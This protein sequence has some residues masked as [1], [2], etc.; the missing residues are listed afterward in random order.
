MAGVPGLEPRL[1]ESKSD[2]LPLHYTPTVLLV[3]SP[4]IEL[5]IHPYHGCVMPLNYKSVFGP[6]ART[7]TWI[8]QLSVATEYKPAVLPLNYRRI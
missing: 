4:R 3:L 7:R 2:V 6:P 1:A 5:G 8:S